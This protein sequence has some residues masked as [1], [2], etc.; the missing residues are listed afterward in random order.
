MQ[1]KLFEQASDTW[2]FEELR[3]A[4]LNLERYKDSEEMVSR[5]EQEAERHKQ[6]KLEQEKRSKKTEKRKKRRKRFV[7]WILVLLSLFIFWFIKDIVV[8][9]NRMD[10]AIKLVEQ[11]EIEEGIKGIEAEEA[12][13]FTLSHKAKVYAFA[14]AF[15]NE[16]SYENAMK[17][18]SILGDYE[19]S[20]EKVKEASAMIN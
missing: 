8:P 19:D 7:I 18:Y 16:G 11:G 9:S 5:C 10:R 15:M 6:S 13:V 12:Y 14:D 17:L 4:F 2:E 20:A 3:D 1:E